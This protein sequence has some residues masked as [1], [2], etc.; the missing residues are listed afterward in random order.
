MA[1]E[2]L[3]I[4]EEYLSIVVDIIELGLLTTSVPV[5]HPAWQRLNNWCKE[6]DDYLESLASR[7]EEE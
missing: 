5:N 4:P 1:K 6:M 3:A 2:I 7:L